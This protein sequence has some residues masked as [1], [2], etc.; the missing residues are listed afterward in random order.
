MNHGREVEEGHAQS[1]HVWGP[2]DG[3]PTYC[4]RSSALLYRNLNLFFT[5]LLGLL[6]GLLLTQTSITPLPCTQ[7]PNTPLELHTRIEKEIHQ[8]IHR[9]M[10]KSLRIPE[11]PRTSKYERMH[12]M[13]L[14]VDTHE[15]INRDKQNC[16]AF[17]RR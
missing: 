16:R 8:M 2:R 15:M 11:A 9:T 4:I 5:L 13:P 7:K 1:G 12:C 10:H 6:L 17:Y 14:R 3:A